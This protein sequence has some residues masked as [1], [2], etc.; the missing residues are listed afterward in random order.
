MKQNRK[1]YTVIVEDNNIHIKRRDELMENILYRLSM[2]H[3]YVD[4]FDDKLA[5]IIYQLD[6]IKQNQEKKDYDPI[7]DDDPNVEF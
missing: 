3:E 5:S 7:M 6:K 2:I 4:E 1:V